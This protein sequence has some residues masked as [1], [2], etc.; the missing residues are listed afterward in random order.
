M[1]FIVKKTVILSA[2]YLKGKMH[3]SS[4]HPLGVPK[5]FDEG[6]GI[7]FENRKLKN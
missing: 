5:W 6:F 3:L 4:R 1:T 7:L 2:I